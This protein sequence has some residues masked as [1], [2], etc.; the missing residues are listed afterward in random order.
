[1]SGQHATRAPSSA[2][3]WTRC[4]G[5]VALEAQ[6]PDTS[7]FYAQWGTAAHELAS[8]CLE[9]VALGEK[10]YD[11]I[12]AEAFLGRII[13]VDPDY[14]AQAVGILGTGTP[15][16]VDMEMATCVN[17]YIQHVSM[18][19]DP[20]AGDILLVEQKL[21]I[22][23]ITGEAGATGTSDVVGIT[24]GG[25]ELVIIDLKGGQGVQVY[26]TDNEQLDM[27]AGGALKEYGLLYDIRTVRKVIS[28]PRLDH[29]DE[30]VLTVAE[31]EE[32]LA[33]IEL[34]AAVTYTAERELEHLRHDGMDIWA[35][36]YLDP[37]EKQCRFC[38]AKA[39]CPAL[40]GFVTDALAATHDRQRI[41]PAT[42]PK[43][44]AAV[45]D[46]DTIGLLGAEA[47][48]EAMRAADLVELWI[49]AVR[50]QVT[51]LLM[52]GE[53]VPGFKVVQGKKGARRWKNAAEAEELMK[54]GRL[55][56]EQMFT[57][58]LI[59][60]PAAEKLLKANQKLWAKLAPLIG[61]TDGKPTVAPE[62]DPRPALQLGADA[63]EFPMVEGEVDLLA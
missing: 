24:Q 59:T 22:E 17:D 54:K 47:L 43:L 20:A 61:Q 23:H 13:I 36:D 60:P 44:A 32:R 3:R 51:H 35:K 37:G 16:E 7:S 39:T 42:L 49:T 55:K 1:M 63:E 27:Y 31:L 58:S 25:T 18:F 57:R 62:A 21:S 28:Q 9:P 10:T 53:T 46:K 52:H 12:D 41:P 14:D 2:H 5:S 26:A 30:E 8:W 40:T 29:V 34:D 38:K 4:P 48:A 33:S 15:F 56:S 50:G 19:I 11:E 6:L 45:A